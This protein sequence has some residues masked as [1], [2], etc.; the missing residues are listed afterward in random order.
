MPLLAG[1]QKQR[2]ASSTCAERKS[3]RHIQT[4]VYSDHETRNSRPPISTWVCMAPGVHVHKLI[5]RQKATPAEQQ[6]KSS[7]ESG[8]AKKK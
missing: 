6:T 1:T 2:I 3:H 5:P 8:P 4:R 7:E